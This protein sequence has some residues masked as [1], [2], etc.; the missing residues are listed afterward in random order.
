[1]PEPVREHLDAALASPAGDDLVDA[2]GV[3]PSGPRLLIP[4]HSCGRVRLG[5]PGA[6]PDVPV[7]GAGGVVADLD[8]PG[9]LWGTTP[10][11]RTCGD[12]VGPRTRNSARFP[13]RQERLGNA[14]GA[15][16][17][18]SRWLRYPHNGG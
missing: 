1:M 16:R 3:P 18:P 7:E 14:N 11:T 8:S 6:D 13:G 2:G 4:S 10:L 9:I 5:V 17:S 15:V 12:S